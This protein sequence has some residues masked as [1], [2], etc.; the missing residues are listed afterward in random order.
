M[1]LTN[2]TFVTV[3]AFFSISGDV[4]N[5]IVGIIKTEALKKMFLKYSDWVGIFNIIIPNNHVRWIIFGMIIVLWVVIWY[6]RNI[7]TEPKSISKIPLHILSHSTMGKTQFKLDE[8]LLKMFEPDIIELDLIKEVKEKN[9]CYDKFSYIV[10]TQDNFIE[11]FKSDINNVDKFGY[12]GISHTPLIL[13]AGYKM[14][15]EIKFTLLHKKRNLDYYEQLNE[16]EE[17]TDINIEKKI[18]RNSEELIVAISTTFQIRDTELDA[19]QPDNK[20]ILKFRTDE[21]GYDVI[22]SKKQI[23]KYLNFIFSE[24]RYIVKEKGIVKIH[25]AI[26]SSVAFTFALGQSISDHYDPEIVV[27]H[28]DMSKSKKYPWG[29]S[30]FNNYSDCIIVN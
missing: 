30:L 13:R 23:E 7:Y 25:M 24:I 11:K 21:M 12:M 26:S 1:K 15:D 22:M 9:E 29:I 3:V 14:G 5:S 20:S 8:D 18:M 10:S 6:F 19:L 17:Y 28:F 16:S 2:I 4:S 27:Y